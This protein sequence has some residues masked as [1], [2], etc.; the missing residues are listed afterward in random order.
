[1]ILQSLFVLPARNSS[2][3]PMLKQ[4][5]LRWQ[6]PL[7][8]V[9]LRLLVRL[10]GWQFFGFGH[11]RHENL[12]LT[13]QQINEPEAPLC[14]SCNAHVLFLRTIHVYV[15]VRTRERNTLRFYHRH[16]DSCWGAWRCSVEYPRAS[17][18]TASVAPLDGKNRLQ[19]PEVL[20]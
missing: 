1:M 18:I 12:L 5:S 11:Y 14:N 8:T 4:R 2:R 19:A 13:A 17:D 7:M 6:Q 20:H 16:G 9:P 15:W 10:R 3:L